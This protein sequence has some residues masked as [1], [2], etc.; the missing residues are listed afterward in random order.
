M[1][2]TVTNSIYFPD[3]LDTQFCNNFKKIFPKEGLEVN[4]WDFQLRPSGYGHFK[5][6]LEID[7]NYYGN[8]AHKFTYIKTT[9]DMPLIDSIKRDEFGVD[10]RR[11]IISVISNDTFIE[12]LDE[13]LE[14]IK[15]NEDESIEE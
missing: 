13:F 14:T 9:S 8:A 5:M 3:G 2:T 10:K 4:L 1:K 11:A 6:I 15:P 7:V 12:E